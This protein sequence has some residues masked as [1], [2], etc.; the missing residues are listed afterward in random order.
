MTAPKSPS[1][2]DQTTR[3]FVLPG[4]HSAW[5]SKGFTLYLELADKVTKEQTARA[6]RLLFHTRSTS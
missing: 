6:L 2:A 3:L 5:I 4:E 1:K